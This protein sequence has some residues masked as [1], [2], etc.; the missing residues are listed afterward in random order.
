HETGHAILDAIRPDLWNIASSEIWAFHESFAD[1]CAIS[2]S[3]DYPWAINAA[4]SE[5]DGDLSKS[6]II[7]KIGEHIANS[8]N[9]DSIRDAT[10]KFNY[11][12]PEKLP[13]F[14]PREKLTSDP[15]SLG[16]VFLSAW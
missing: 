3:I 4:L 16:R 9:L 14:G 7:S 12:E 15:H 2:A 6:N 8:F 5:T 10:I 13:K 1:I 11:V